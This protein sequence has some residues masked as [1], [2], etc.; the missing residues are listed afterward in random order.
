MP[1]ESNNRN[2]ERNR[3]SRGRRRRFKGAP[4]EAAHETVVKTPSNVRRSRIDMPTRS[5]KSLNNLS[6]IDKET[7]SDQGNSTNQN[8]S[9]M[10]FT[11]II[12]WCKHLSQTRETPPQMTQGKVVPLER[13]HSPPGNQ[14]TGYVGKKREFMGPLGLGE[15]VESMGGGFDELDQPSVSPHIQVKS[16]S[17]IDISMTNLWGNEDED[18]DIE[19]GGVVENNEQENSIEKDRRVSFS[20]STRSSLLNTISR[21][22]PLPPIAPNIVQFLDNPSVSGSV[23]ES[24]ET[25][26]FGNNEERWSTPAFVITACSQMQKGD[27]FNIH[28]VSDYLAELKL[29][30]NWAK[31]VKYLC[32]GEIRKYKSAGRGKR[33]RH[34]TRQGSTMKTENEVELKELHSDFTN[35]L[36]SYE[37]FVGQMK[38]EHRGMSISAILI[39]GHNERLVSM[40]TVLPMPIPTLQHENYKAIS[41]SA[42]R[43]F[44]CE[45]S[46]TAVFKAFNRPVEAPCEI[47]AFLCSDSLLLAS[48]CC[49]LKSSTVNS[50]PGHSSSSKWSSRY[51]SGI[52]TT[53]LQRPSGVFET[54]A[55]LPLTFLGLSSPSSASCSSTSTPQTDLAIPVVK[56][57]P[58]LPQI[59]CSSSSGISSAASTEEDMEGGSENGSSGCGGGPYEITNGI[60]LWWPPGNNCQLGLSIEKRSS[61]QWLTHLQTILEQIQSCFSSQILR[62]K[63]LNEIAPEK[64]VHKYI[65]LGPSITTLELK[66]KALTAMNIGCQ[67]VDAEIVASFSE[68]NR[69]NLELTLSDEDR[70]FLLALYVTTLQSWCE[71]L[72]DEN[73]D[74]FAFDQADRSFTPRTLSFPL[75]P[76]RIPITFIIRDSLNNGIHS[77]LLHRSVHVPGEVDIF[78]PIKGFTDRPKSTMYPEINRSHRPHLRGLSQ[79]SHNLSAT[80]APANISGKGRSRS[81]LRLPFSRINLTSNEE[82]NVLDEKDTLSNQFGIF[83]RLPKEAWPDCRVSMSVM[84]LFV[85]I[86]YKGSLTEGIF[87]KSV[88]MSQLQ[89][90]IQRVDTDEDPL[91]V[92][93]CSP[94]CAA[95]ILK[96]YFNEIPGHLLIDDKWDEWCKLVTFKTDEEIVNYAKK[97]LRE[98]PDINQSLLTFLLFTLAQIRVNS[99]VNKM[100]VEALATVWGPNLLERPNA[101]PSVE[102]SNMCTSIISCLLGSFTDVCVLGE[103][104]TDFRQKLSAFFDEIWGQMIPKGSNGESTSKPPPE[105][106]SILELPEIET[107]KSTSSESPPIESPKLVEPLQAKGKRSS[108]MIHSLS[109]EEPVEVVSNFRRYLRTIKKDSKSSS[110]QE[111]TDLPPPIPPRNR[112]KSTSCSPGLPVTSI[113]PNPGDSDMPPPLPARTYT[114]PQNLYLSPRENR[115]KYGMINKDSGTTVVDRRRS[116]SRRRY[117]SRSPVRSCTIDIGLS[118]NDRRAYM[119]GDICEDYDSLSL[120]TPSK[121]KLKSVETTTNIPTIQRSTSDVDANLQNKQ[122]MTRKRVEKDFPP[123]FEPNTDSGGVDFPWNT[124]SAR[125]TSSR[126]HRCETRWTCGFYEI[127]NFDAPMNL[128]YDKTEDLS[129]IS[130]RVQSDA[131]KEIKPAPVRQRP[132]AIYLDENANIVFPDVKK[133][134][135]APEVPAGICRRISSIYEQKK[136][137][138]I[139]CGWRNLPLRNSIMGPDQ[140]NSSQQVTGTHLSRGS[141]HA[142]TGSSTSTTLGPN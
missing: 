87:R 95:N 79:S 47:S 128:N 12:K 135:P 43:K 41:S 115:K 104:S 10:P 101:A 70:P 39:A 77:S 119:I 109:V 88:V 60:G 82:E 50:S 73:I 106:I 28:C 65:A 118:P 52:L 103:S 58:P 68:P 107:E 36:D 120:V 16:R 127:P 45:V 56:I 14:Q 110:S 22:V 33:Q 142:S 29:T 6:S 38:E 24:M 139:D 69:G 55:R 105:G 85:V 122:L 100:S 124:V 37:M 83:G 66:E 5:A 49:Q 89:T 17:L 130:R 74:F 108:W 34:L 32:E 25:T 13:K 117:P 116:F 126:N 64:C 19:N 44:L 81:R 80:G 97:I 140:L 35:F 86:F 31:S 76:D 113:T 71:K 92:D 134:S 114:S 11:R 51:P 59:L 133:T 3:E 137:Q 121:S 75:P 94:L 61:Q 123:F 129:L 21:L 112:Q 67:P 54:L 125:R 8:T 141:S 23:Y 96:K 9:L 53:P 42:Y 7:T 57:T 136:M 18:S 98:L 27:L 4:F 102:D 15:F 46:A 1:T 2:Y 93:E 138:S 72:P 90:M 63:V 30:V 111:S 48:K 20:Q 26:F 132:T 78:E 40:K 99:A 131:I 91:M 62:V 84:S